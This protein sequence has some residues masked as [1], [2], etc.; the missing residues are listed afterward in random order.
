MDFGSLAALVKI[1][2]ALNARALVT[3]DHR[4]R[5]DEALLADLVAV[6]QRREMVAEAFT[7][8]DGGVLIGGRDVDLCR[9]EDGVGQDSGPLCGSLVDLIIVVNRR[10]STAR[11]ARKE[12]L[13]YQSARGTAII[14]LG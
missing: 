12:T 6:E 4:T 1:A 3:P 8:Q 7:D 10:R 13:F 5:N 2:A 14:S 9:A 11:G